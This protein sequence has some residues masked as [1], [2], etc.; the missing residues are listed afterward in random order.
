[1]LIVSFLK[2]YTWKQKLFLILEEYLGFTVRY[3][4]SYEGM[5]LRWVFYKMTFKKLGWHP[6]IW[7]N[8][9]ITHGFNI[10][11][12]DNLCINYGAHLDGRGGIKIGN[13]VLIG[14]NVFIGS[15]NHLIRPLEKIPRLFMGHRAK[16]VGIGSNVW[17]GANAV[18]CPGVEIGNNSI[19]GAGGIV[20]SNIPNNVIA[21][22]NP[23]KII[24][25]LK[26]SDNPI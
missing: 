11:A 10:I 2:R 19:I 13:Q 1:M 4:P 7:P 6:Y 23:A 17:I 18:I 9:Y 24:T 14:P 20:T 21:G 8:V 3:L 16:P 5:L 26:K 25:A 22:G 12:G 15:S